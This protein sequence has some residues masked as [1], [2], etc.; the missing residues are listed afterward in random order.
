MQ[1]L[2]VSERHDPDGVV[3]VA[4]SGELDIATAPELEACFTRLAE[5]GHHRLVLDAALLTFCDASGI[6]VLIKARAR[7]DEER[8]WLRLAAVS[9]RLHRILTTL[10]LLTVLPAFEDVYR[11]VLAAEPPDQVES[12][13]ESAGLRAA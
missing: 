5:A 10:A 1:Q 8:G 3:V 2:S 11:A 9:P 6:R 13:T 7:A 4:V 12:A